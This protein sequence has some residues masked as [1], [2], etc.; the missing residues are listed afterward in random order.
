M[1]I[2]IREMKANLKSLLIWSIGVLAMVIAGMGKY[3]G[4]KGTGQTMNELM[5]EMPK[6]LQAI[7]GTSGFDLATAL[8]FY[9]LLY[10]Y[11]IVMASIHAVMLGANI[12]AKE[13][14]D[15][16]AE[17]LLVKPV[18]RA[19]V[20]SMK[21]LTALIHIVLFN[22]VTLLSSI[23]MVERF[24]E[25]ETVTDGLLL[26]M[27]GMFILQLIFLLLGSVVAAVYR[28]S[29]KASV[30]STGIMLVLFI[31]SIL[32]NMTEKIEMLKY[33]TPFKYFEAATILNNGKLEPVFLFL[34]VFL[35]LAFTTLTYRFYQKKDL[36]L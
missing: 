20:I 2:M 9:G 19:K 12:I 22:L 27:S 36:N 31:L 30:I 13:E 32:I 33:I 11:L 23:I 34:S 14:R 24:A 4:M 5:A 3:A 1:N 26:L 8:G 17:F 29:K 10:L 15:K 21:L 7:M 18:S 35:I 25:A 6:S 16:T 28:K